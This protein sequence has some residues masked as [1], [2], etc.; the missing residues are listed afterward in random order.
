MP[1]LELQDDQEESALAFSKHIANQ[2]HNIIQYSNDKVVAS[3]VNQGGGGG[4]NTT[5]N[6]TNSIGDVVNVGE[7]VSQKV[8]SEKIRGD[9]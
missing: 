6:A 4:G 1:P 8:I 9:H 3:E 7:A 5:E 2:P